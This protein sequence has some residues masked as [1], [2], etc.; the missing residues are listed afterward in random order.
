MINLMQIGNTGSISTNNTNSPVYRTTNAGSDV[1]GHFFIDPANSLSS[2]IGMVFDT[3]LSGFTQGNSTRRILGAAIE[4]VNLSSSA[5]AERMDLGFF[6]QT[7]GAAIAQRLQLGSTA[8]TFSDAVDLVFNTSTGSKIG[9]STSQK[10]GFYNATP[11]V[12]QAATTDLATAFSNLGLRA[13]GTAFPITTTGIIS[14]SNHVN[15]YS[16]TAT[17]A[18]TTTLTNASNRINQFTGST[19]QTV[20]LPVV[21]TLSN[22]W[23]FKIVNTSSGVVT[24]QTSGSNSIKAMAAN[25]FLDVWVINTAGGTG[26]AS[27]NW[28]YS[29]SVNN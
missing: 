5:G 1:L 22:G 14:S 2:G 12:Q 13:S 25:S 27:W 16:T 15:G 24:V 29:T 3:G 20:T 28:F 18:G 4:P 21:T 23:L 6:T 19:T 11:V 7:G 10:I 8:L 9:T 26:T 17:A